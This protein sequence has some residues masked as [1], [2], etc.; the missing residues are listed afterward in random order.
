MGE[1]GRE[2]CVFCAILAGGLPAVKVFE[3]PNVVAILDKRPI[4]PGHTLVI[5]KKHYHDLLELPE[6]DIPHLFR[7]VRRVAAALK[8]SLGADGIN[9]GVNNGEAA[10]QRVF[11][12]HVHIVPRYFGDAPRWGWPTRKDAEP[13]ELERVAARIRVPPEG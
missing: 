3:D 2:D 4:N 11:H 9:I 12:V 1:G 7:A 6:E 13:A 10:N 8:A 5:T